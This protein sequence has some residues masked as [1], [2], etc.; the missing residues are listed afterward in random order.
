RQDRW[1]PLW[2]RANISEDDKAL[3]TRSIWSRRVLQQRVTGVTYCSGP[4]LGSSCPGSGPPE[5]RCSERPAAR[6]SRREG[7][8]NDLFAGYCR[9]QR[10]ARKLGSSGKWR[11]LQKSAHNKVITISC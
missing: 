2:P 5:R 8:S 4:F 1:L 10:I 9:R 7:L 6:Q 3:P 11:I